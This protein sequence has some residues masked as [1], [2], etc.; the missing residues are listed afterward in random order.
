MATINPPSTEDQPPAPPEYDEPVREEPEEPV[1]EPETEP[2]RATTLPPL[3]DPDG[4]LEALE[5]RSMPV[6][7]VLWAIDKKGEVHEETFTQQGLSWFGKLE[8]YGL[9]GQAVKVVLEG[10]S[11]LG[12]GSMFDMVQKPRQMIDDLMGNLPGADTVPDMTA[13]DEDVDIEAG[14]ILAAF[15]QVVQ[16][17]PELLT[18]AYCIALAIPKSHRPWAV[19]W[20]FPNMDDEMGKDILHAFIDQNWGVMEDFFTKELPKIVKRVT[21]A[22]KASAGRR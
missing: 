6:A 12:I 1:E 20:A 9:L 16:I 22:R 21:K 8:L 13:S 10:D 14:R 2:E 15:A 18:Q 19:T 5:D 17:A 11:P 7:R 4:E 3:V